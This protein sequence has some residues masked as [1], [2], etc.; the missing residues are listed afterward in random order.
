MNGDR[1]MAISCMRGINITFA[2]ICSN[3][4]TG[5]VAKLIRPVDSMGLG[6]QIVGARYHLEA[7]GQIL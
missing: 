7:C 4:S 2:V 1:L 5:K 3:F 6:S